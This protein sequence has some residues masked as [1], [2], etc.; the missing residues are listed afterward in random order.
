MNWAP[1]PGWGVTDRVLALVRITSPFE[2]RLAEELP[3]EVGRAPASL[4]DCLKI[5]PNPPGRATS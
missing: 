1:I 3:D 5:A 4:D 2:H